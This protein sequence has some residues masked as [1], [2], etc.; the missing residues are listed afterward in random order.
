VLI[1]KDSAGHYRFPGR[2]QGETPKG[3]E[4]VYL[5]TTADVRRFEK[6]IN[7]SER[8]RYF[9]HK[10]RT[11]AK[12]QEYIQESRAELR[13]RMRKMSAYGRELAE[14]AIRQN[15]NCSSVDTRFDP[16]FHLNAFSFDSGNRD[17]HYDRDLSKRK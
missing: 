8:Q 15:D 3:Y 7:E 9:S 10:E 14:A 5:K 17:A 13:Q 12:F 1:Y 6:Q 11:E 4:P 2:N 16:Q